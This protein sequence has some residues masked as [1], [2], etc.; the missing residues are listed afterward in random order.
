MGYTHYWNLSQELT[1]QHWAEFT[2]GVERL[3]KLAAHQGIRLAW[4][5]DEPNRKPLIDADTVRFNGVDDE[6]HETFL[7]NRS[8]G[9]EFC[10]TARRPYDI[11]VT[12]AL[13]YLATTHREVFSAGSD[14]TSEEWHHGLELAHKAWPDRIIKVPVGVR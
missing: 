4:E 14:G 3:V 1:A 7:I 2:K 6:G 13:C 8:G 11:V 10:K 5:Y 9:D 12:A